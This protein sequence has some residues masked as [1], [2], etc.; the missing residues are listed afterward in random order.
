MEQKEQAWTAWWASR[1]LCSDDGSQ[2]AWEKQ[3]AVLREKKNWWFYTYGERYWTR[4]D[5][6]EQWRSYWLEAHGEHSE[7]LDG[8]EKRAWWQQTFGEAYACEP[9]PQPSSGHLT[10]IRARAERV[11]AGGAARAAAPVRRP[12]MKHPIIFACSGCDKMFPSRAGCDAHVE[13][14]HSS[15][16]EVTV[17]LHP[18]ATELELKACLFANLPSHDKAML[19]PGVSSSDMDLC[20]VTKR[21]V[22]REPWDAEEGESLSAW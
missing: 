1:P 9:A 3:R 18:Q 15:A 4:E 21:L 20:Y 22:L 5:K 12:L 7:P 19:S 13:T 6:E 16:A 8:H 14:I 17:L 2:S 10:S 11:A